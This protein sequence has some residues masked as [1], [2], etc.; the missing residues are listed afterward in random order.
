MIDLSKDLVFAEIP[1]WLVSDDA[2]NINLQNF[3]FDRGFVWVKSGKSLQDASGRNYL[4]INTR[5]EVE[6]DKKM[7][8]SMWECN[9]PESSEALVKLRDRCTELSYAH[10]ENLISEMPRD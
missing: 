3:L 5:L 9:K 4:I 6:T 7:V 2:F 10:L 8:F 1:D